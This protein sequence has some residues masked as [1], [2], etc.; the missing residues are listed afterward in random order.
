MRFY[1]ENEDKIDNYL[2]KREE[3]IDLDSSKDSQAVKMEMLALIEK[4]PYIIG[5]KQN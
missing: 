5:F 2:K 3:T 1:Q 4:S